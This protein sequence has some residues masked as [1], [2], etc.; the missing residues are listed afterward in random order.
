MAFKLSAKATETVEY[1][2]ALLKEADHFAALVEQFATAKKGGDMYAAQ[3]SRELGQLR[4]KAMARNLGFIADSAGQLGVVASRTGSAVMKGRMLRD[5]VVS[6]RGLIERSI[7]GTITADENEQKEKEFLAEKER[8]TQAEHIRARVLAEEA[9][10]AEKAATAGQGAPQAGAGAPG[11]APPKPPASG[12]GQPAPSRAGAPAAAPGAAARPAGPR[13]TAPETAP[14]AP[15]AAPGSSAP[16]APRPA[17]PASPA[18]PPVRPAAP[19]GPQ[20]A[21]PRP[22]APGSQTPAAR[23]AP[24]SP[25]GPA[26]APAQPKVPEP[27][28]AKP[29]P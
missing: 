16:A 26:A 24:Q 22:A 9:R 12:P 1:L 17:A 13:P 28:P 27:A 25:A 5:G 21:A 18:Q 15:R 29:Q 2:E 11:V 10:E 23:P 19:A 8:K 20:P 4:Q 3:L 6:F 7:K 14:A